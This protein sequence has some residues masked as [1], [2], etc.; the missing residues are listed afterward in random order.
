MISR[1]Y[2]L[3]KLLIFG[4]GLFLNVNVAMA[5]EPVKTAA[6][7]TI[8]KEWSPD[9]SVNGEF[10]QD[11]REW[12]ASIRSKRHENMALANEVHVENIPHLYEVENNDFP[13]EVLENFVNK[14]KKEIKKP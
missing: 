2:A 12:L 7:L 3:P 13:K 14:I 4:G 8:M 9:G 1:I 11:R 10:E 6:D 5:D